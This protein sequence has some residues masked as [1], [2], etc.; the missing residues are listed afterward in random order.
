MFSSTTSTDGEFG[1]EGTTEKESKQR[2]INI[3]D[4]LIAES[5]IYDKGVEQ[6]D[7]DLSNIV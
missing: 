1:V 4:L 6:M 7:G 5:H 2:M 3:L